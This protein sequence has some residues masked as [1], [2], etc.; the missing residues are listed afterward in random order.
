MAYDMVA[1]MHSDVKRERK[2]ER[3]EKD[4]IVSGVRVNA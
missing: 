4:Q 3:C 2:R 1:L